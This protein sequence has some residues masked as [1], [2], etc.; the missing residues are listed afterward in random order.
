MHGSSC[1][2]CKIAG[3]VSVAVYA[4]VTLITLYAA[5]NTHFA[6]DG[7]FVAGTPEGSLAVLT[8]IFAFHML[9]KAIKKACPC[10]CGGG[11]GCG[12]ACNCGDAPMQK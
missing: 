2:G 1:L 9:M 11:C 12:G 3:Y 8:V 7:T 6:A 5:Y 10:S 4:V